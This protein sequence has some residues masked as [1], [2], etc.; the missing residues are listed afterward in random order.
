MSRMFIST[1]ELQGMVNEKGLAVGHLMM[2]CVLSFVC[3]CVCVCVSVQ[4]RKGSG[5]LSAT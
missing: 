3:V 1:E 4:W 5:V 2:R